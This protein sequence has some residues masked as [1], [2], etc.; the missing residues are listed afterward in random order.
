MLQPPINSD[1]A[2]EAHSLDRC[3]NCGRYGWHETDRCPESTVDT[4]EQGR[5]TGDRYERLK[6]A[7][8]ILA[9]DPNVRSAPVPYDSGGLRAFATTIAADRLLDG[10]TD[11]DADTVAMLTMIDFSGGLRRMAWRVADLLSDK[12]SFTRDYDRKLAVVHAQV[13]IFEM[14]LRELLDAD[15]DME[16]AL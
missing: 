9:D 15:A 3:E 6:Q 8:A 13:A 7:T 16:P 2:T 4:D 11:R 10:L 1:Q 12:P 14:V 5:F